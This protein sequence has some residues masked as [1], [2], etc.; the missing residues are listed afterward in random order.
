MEEE[1]VVPDAH[2]AG[3]HLYGPAATIFDVFL[4][5]LHAPDWRPRKLSLPDG[6]S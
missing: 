4:R 5:G 1:P 2:A 3:K 6:E